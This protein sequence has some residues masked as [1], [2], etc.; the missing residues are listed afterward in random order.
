MRSMTTSPPTGSREAT[1]PYYLRVRDIC[2]PN[3]ILPISRSHFYA[4][5]AA[6]KIPAGRR[7][8]AGCVVWTRDQL[9]VALG[10]DDAR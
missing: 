1:S 6:K 8:S 9:A 2:R 10:L 7:L 4:L 5:V 3:G